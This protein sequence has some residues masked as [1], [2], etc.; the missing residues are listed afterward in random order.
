MMSIFKRGSR[1]KDSGGVTQML[2]MLTMEQERS[3][4]DQ[5]TFVPARRYSIA[6][7]DR[8]TPETYMEMKPMI[9]HRASFTSITMLEKERI[10]ND[11][12]SIETLLQ[13][14][15]RAKLTICRSTPNLSDSPKTEVKKLVHKTFSGTQFEKMTRSL[16]QLFSRMTSMNSLTNMFRHN[17]DE[18]L[19]EAEDLLMN[20]H[21]YD[22]V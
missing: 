20:G 14:L 22:Q 17:K 21:P 4:P 9:K 2:N 8:D 5:Q 10:F 16:S 6:A 7:I 19:L 13:P 18:T 11:P 3:S 1:R 12:I 15:P